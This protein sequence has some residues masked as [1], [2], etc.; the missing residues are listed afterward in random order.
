MTAESAPPPPVVR[1]EPLLVSD[2][3]YVIPDNHV[4]I[5]PNVGIVVGTRATL[6]IDTGLGQDN[7]AYV[8]EH[9]RRLGSG[10]PV[11]VATTHVD[12]GHGFGMAAFK[13]K[14]RIVFHRSQVEEMH[15]LGHGY[16]DTFSRLRPELTPMLRSVE[17]VEPDIVFCDGDLEVDL[18][19]HGAVLRHYGPAHAADDQVVLVDDHVLFAGDLVLTG[20]FPIVPYFP[21]FEADVDANHWIDVLDELMSLQPAI[22]VPGHGDLSDSRAIAEVRDFLTYVRGMASQ[23]RANGASPDD[24][25]ASIEAAARARWPSWGASLHGSSGFAGR[26]FYAASTTGL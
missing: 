10:R 16:I 3:V 19:G 12:P 6:V 9:A 25:G 15:R 14:A 26:A 7:G 2:G 13:R 24:A 8:L 1:G 17:F 21:P 11:Y 22:V 4:P 5:V 20:Q 18:G 23:L